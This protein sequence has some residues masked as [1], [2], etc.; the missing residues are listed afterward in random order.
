MRDGSIILAEVYYDEDGVTPT[1][2]ADCRDVFYCGVLE[3]Y[4][5]EWKVLKSQYDIAFEKPLLDEMEFEQE[6]G[7][8]ES[9]AD[10]MKKEEE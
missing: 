3:D 8:A 2:Y 7:F 9:L 4:H 1:M 6:T 5:D 10:V